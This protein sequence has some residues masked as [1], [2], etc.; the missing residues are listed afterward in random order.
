VLKSLRNPCEALHYYATISVFFKGI[1]RTY[2]GRMLMASDPHDGSVGS[3]L[4]ACDN[5]F[6]KLK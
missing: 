6:K 2:S 1:H 3:I 5:L 4:I